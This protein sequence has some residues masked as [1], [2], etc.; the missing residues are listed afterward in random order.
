MIK[1]I[2]KTIPNKI[3]ITKRS[4]IYSIE[5]FIKK[6]ALMILFI[7]FSAS[8][9]DLFQNKMFLFLVICILGL[10]LLS[11]KVYFDKIVFQI[12]IYMFF[13]QL[14]AMIRFPGFGDDRFLSLGLTFTKFLLAYF[15][16]KIGGKDFF[17]WFEKISFMLIVIG[18]PLFFLVQ[19]VPQ[20]SQILSRF[21]LNSIADQRINGGWNIFVYVHSGWARFRFC[22]YAWEPGGMALMI[23]LSWIFYILYNGV[24]INY[25]V[26]IYFIAMA[27]TFS[28]TG[29]FVLALM[30]IFYIFNRKGKSFLFFGIPSLVFLILIFPYVWRQD[31]MQGKIQGY[32]KRDLAT[33]NQF[34]QSDNYSYSSNIGR[35][36]SYT[37]GTRDI[38]KW[39]FGHG[40]VDAGRTKNVQGVVLSGANAIVNFTIVWGVIGLVFLLYSLYIFIY[41]RN[42]YIKINYK[43]LLLISILLVF[44]SNPVTSRPVLYTIILY[45][46]LFKKQFIPKK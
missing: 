45:P 35:L 29:Y 13:V 8:I 14:I 1:I 9:I 17:Y 43:F 22:G 5:S 34:D 39:P 27:F 24:N 18:L 40:T 12:L 19:Y 44:S 30:V 37:V 31:F 3:L 20:V 15:I 38:I 42:K 41:K 26:I 7:G 16:I 25:R 32:I 2:Q 10:L 36:G 21:D 6:Y 46:F 28:T 33:R 4:G 23:T 11:K